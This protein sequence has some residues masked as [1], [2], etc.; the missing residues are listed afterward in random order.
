MKRFYVYILC[1]RS[2]VLYVGVT[3]DLR[4]RVY[5]HKNKLILGFTSKYNVNRLVYYF[6]CTDAMQA[7]RNEK[8]IKGW[9]RE[10]KIALI[11]GMNPQW[12]DLSEAWS[13]PGKEVESG[14]P[15]RDPS[16]RSG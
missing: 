3:S 8:R 16:L 15:A 13:D 6:E 5:Q 10:K 14:S 9:T 7:I 1:S 4:K 11:E 12:R 2:G